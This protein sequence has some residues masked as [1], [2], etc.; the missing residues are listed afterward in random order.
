MEHVQD[1]ASE[2]FEKDDGEAHQC[3][4]KYAQMSTD[5]HRRVFTCSP[6]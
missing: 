6:A 5:E 3:T 1:L 2:Y 4:E